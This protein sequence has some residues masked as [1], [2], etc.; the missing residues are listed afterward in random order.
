MRGKN[1]GT[2]ALCSM[3]WR[4]QPTASA[5]GHTSKLSPSILYIYSIVYYISL[6]CSWLF[7]V[8][9]FISHNVSYM[10]VIPCL[11][12]GLSLLP[13]FC[14][15]R[16][17]NI[18]RLLCG[19]LL[20]AKLA[21]C[22]NLRSHGNASSHVY[23]G[24]RDRDAIAFLITG[25]SPASLVSAISSVS[26]PRSHVNVIANTVRG[27]TLEPGSAFVSWARLPGDIRATR[28]RINK[29]AL[30]ASVVDQEPDVD[31]YSVLSLPND[32]SE[33]DIKKRHDELKESLKSL[34]SVDKRI[35]NKIKEAYKVL[36]N[37]ASR[38]LYDEKLR[39]RA[40]EVSS[41]DDTSDTEYDSDDIEILGNPDEEFGIDITDNE[42]PARSRGGLTGFLGNLFGFNR[43]YSM[44]P[45][46]S[47][48][49]RD[50]TTTASVDLKALVF[51]DTVKVPIEKYCP[52][53]DCNSSKS[54]QQK[55]ISRC[56]KCSGRGMITKNQ[57]TPFGYIST[58]RTCMQCQGR[59]MARIQDCTTCNNS[60]RVYKSTEV[61][62]KIP[63]G[64]KVGSTLKVKGKG[65]SSG[66]SS[67][68]GNLYVK[69]SSSPNEHEYIDM[70]KVYTTATL[71]YVS[72]ILGDTVNVYTFCGKKQVTVPPGTQS[73]DEFVVG[74]YDNKTHMI[75]FKV[76]VPKKATKE[77][78]PLSSK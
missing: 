12:V 77:E 41:D 62:I 7:F 40:E 63:A 17:R 48:N 15:R 34:P 13:A 5:I 25:S 52:C 31:Y 28:G 58:S 72:A 44:K 9:L 24:L 19:A 67:R 29:Y 32:C 18:S 16:S 59:G 56:N 4:R 35:M 60:G 10:Y 57:R 23:S 46:R 1:T 3:A 75:R 38:A 30:F 20:C 11:A 51:G 78:A 27:S 2:E 71:D 43:D 64:I 26:T 68:P 45:M 14:Q 69:I 55:Y 21:S 37:P 53:P 36:S 22:V 49:N 65:H 61:E 6:L 42:S 47:V 8:Y 70:D 39:Q 73:G 66:Y 50:L 33:E 74:N 76:T 54:A